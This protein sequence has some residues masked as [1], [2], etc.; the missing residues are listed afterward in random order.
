MNT[1][2]RRRTRVAVQNLGEEIERHSQVQIKEEKD[3]L[4][5]VI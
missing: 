3:I 5:S 2:G 4:C 1:D